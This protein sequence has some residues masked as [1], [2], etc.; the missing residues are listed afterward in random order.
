M[1]SK[2]AVLEG[3]KHSFILLPNPREWE[4]ALNYDVFK[5]HK[6]AR[7]SVTEG[8][9]F[10]AIQDE[11]TDTVD[12]EEDLMDLFGIDEFIYVNQQ[13]LAGVS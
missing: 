6:V 13:E 8:P 10:I 4:T 12:L 1:R 7:V 5:A 3:N 11:R 9:T 2:E